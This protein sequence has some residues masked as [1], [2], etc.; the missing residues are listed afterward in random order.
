MLP[1]IGRGAGYGLRNFSPLRLPAGLQSIG[2]SE[3]R[4]G[5]GNLREKWR[6]SLSRGSSS[7]VK[8]NI[9]FIFSHHLYIP[10]TNYIAKC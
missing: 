2:S 7:I 5:R 4:K 10:F 3:K 6:S 8:I 1:A 9:L